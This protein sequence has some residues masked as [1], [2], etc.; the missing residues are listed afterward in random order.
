[1]KKNNNTEKAVLDAQAISESLKKG[2]ENVLQTLINETLSKYINE[3]EDENEEDFEV[4]DV[5]TEEPQADDEPAVDAE[6]GEDAPADFDAEGADE[7]DSD[8]DDFEVGDG[9]YDVTGEDDETAL[10][11]YNKLN[12]DDEIV[13]TDNGDGSYEFEGE[14][15]QEYVIE[16]PDDFGVEPEED[17]EVEFDVDFDDE[18]EDADIELDLDDDEDDDVDIEIIDDDDLGD[19]DVD[20]EIVDDDEDEMLNEENLGYT[21]SYQRDVMPGLNVNEP[22][23]SKATYSMDGGVPK[24]AKKPW[25]GKGNPKPFGAKKD[26][27][28]ECGIMG[29]VDLEEQQNVGGMVQQHTVSKSNVPSGREDYVPDDSH[30]VSAAG[31]FKGQMQEAMRQLKQLQKENKQYKQAIKSIKESLKEAAITNVNLVQ[32]VKLLSENS[33]TKAE[34][35][36]IVERFTNVKTI[37]E[38]KNLYNTISRELNE[39]KKSPVG[40]E[41]SFTAQSS[42]VLNE[43]TIYKKNNEENPSLNLMNRMN[44]LYK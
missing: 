34:K 12:D 26:E 31:D 41:K 30:E 33:S 3:S 20:I 13:V 35:K 25:A 1:M 16:L 6:D 10:R 27:L 40:I 5:D 28:D 38:G 22:A 43:T 29:D 18:D 23:N 17:A 36:S 21:D 8:L 14:D 42:K 24:D 44:N 7:E 37:A 32:M 11:V 39:S 2:T 9:E 19:D 15:G 4:E